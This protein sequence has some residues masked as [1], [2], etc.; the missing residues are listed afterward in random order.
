MGNLYLGDNQLIK[1]VNNTKYLMITPV[2]Y[3]DTAKAWI[4]E[5]VDNSKTF[6]VEISCSNPQITLSKDKIVLSI[7][8]TTDGKFLPF[9][10]SIRERLI[11]DYSFKNTVTNTGTTSQ[12][13]NADNLFFTIKNCP[14]TGLLRTT[15]DSQYRYQQFFVQK[16]KN[17]TLPAMASG[18]QYTI[19][20]NGSKEISLYLSSGECLIID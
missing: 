13:I 12:N 14:F 11:N 10:A 5:N 3:N 7:I 18:T 4:S 17:Y 1:E 19:D 16:G 9:D 15:G 8:P 6:E 2:S 20:S